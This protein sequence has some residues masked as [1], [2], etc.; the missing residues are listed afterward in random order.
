MNFWRK[1]I[2]AYALLV[3]VFANINISYAQTNADTSVTTN[4]QQTGGDSSQSSEE[5]AAGAKTACDTHWT[6]FN[7]DCLTWLIAEILGMVLYLFSL[8]LSLAVWAFDA[9]INLSINDLHIYMGSDSSVVAAWKILRDVINMIFLLVM[10]YIAVGTVLQLEGVNWKKQIGAIIMAA[11]MINFSLA[12]T[13]IIIDTTNVFALY[14]YEKAQGPADSKTGE[15]QGIANLIFERLAVPDA[16]KEDTGSLE[17][18]PSLGAI[19]VNFLGSILVLLSASYVFFLAAFLFVFRSV[20]LIFSAIFSPLPWI[21]MAIPK[22]G[23]KLSSSWWDSLINNAVFAPVYTFCLYFAIQFIL[24]APLDKIQGGDKGGI[25]PLGMFFVITISLLFGCVMVA[26]KMGAQG[27]SVAQSGAKWVMGASL[28]T[29]GAATAWTLKKTGVNDL[30]KGAEGRVTGA[31]KPITTFMNKAD[32]GKA[33][34]TKT[35]MGYKAVKES[36]TSPLSSVT[37]AVKMGTGIEIMPSDADW[38]AQKKA[39]KEYLAEQE[40]A[41]KKDR[42]IEISKMTEEQIAETATKEGKEE[43]DKEREIGKEIQEL[44]ENFR[45]DKIMDIGLKNLKAQNGRIASW[46]NEAQIKAV[47]N[48]ADTKPEDMQAIQNAIYEN[49]ANVRGIRAVEVDVVSRNWSEWD[50]EKKEEA[51]TNMGSRHV[52]DLSDTILGSD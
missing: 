46:I 7:I 19:I 39:E 40:L 18:S 45:G 2:I 10:M 22:M 42:L 17:N 43:D 38:K 20:A 12:V 47:E 50:K 34:T 3:V 11:V 41:A 5:P 28:G 21:G 33:I 15:R 30:A 23:G 8:L 52:A 6:Y 31:L 24:C 32:L 9:S 13:R 48:H 49:K 25:L 16:L 14:F 29:A 26:Q 4:T 35:G 36:I 1:L 44:L 51:I 37:K 27:M